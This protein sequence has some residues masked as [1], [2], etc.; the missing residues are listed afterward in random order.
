MVLDLQ[1]NELSALGD[2]AIAAVLAALA[3]ARR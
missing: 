2:A 1:I 3:I